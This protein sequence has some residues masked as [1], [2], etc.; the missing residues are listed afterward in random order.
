MHALKSFYKNT[1][2]I[3]FSARRFYIIIINRLINN[4]FKRMTI[5]KSNYLHNEKTI[6]TKDNSFEF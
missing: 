4:F 6:F 5:A 2:P 3:N 1:Q